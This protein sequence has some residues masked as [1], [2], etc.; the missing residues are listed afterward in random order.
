VPA[1]GARLRFDL[2]VHTENTD[3]LYLESTSDGGTTWQPVPFEVR[4]GSTTTGTNGSIG[5]TA[6]R[7]WGR[8]TADL[9]AGVQQV[10]WRY[11]TDSLYFGRGVNVDGVS[12]MA[13]DRTILDGERHP[14][15]FT[16]V[17]WQLA[18]R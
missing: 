4:H 6:V 10:R 17:G 12:V 9:A 2:F 13:G 15:L 5:G 18:N 7:Q 14:D 3:L 16:A 8:A 1:E 11:R